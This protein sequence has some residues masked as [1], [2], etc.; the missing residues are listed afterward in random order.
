MELS[1]K[2]KDT[3]NKLFNEEILLS[4]QRSKSDI[5]QSNKEDTE[6]IAKAFCP[7]FHLSYSYQVLDQICDDVAR[8]P[9]IYK[10][11]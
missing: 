3:S 8:K 5:I 9:K 6:Y 7:F 1:E 4:Q 10:V 2:K 11:F